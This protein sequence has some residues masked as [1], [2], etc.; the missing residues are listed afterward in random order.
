MNLVEFLQN[1]VIKGWKFWNEGEGLYYDAPSEQS[2]S[3]VLA[4]LKQHKAEILQLL[5]ERP[6]IFNVYPLSYGQRALW[7]LWQLAPE[8]HA[9]NVSFA[10]RICS[11]VDMTAMSMALAALMERHP[12]LRTTYPKLGSEPIQ[13]VHQNQELDWLQIDASSWSEEQ[14]KAKVIAAHQILFDLETGP[15][16]RVRWFSCSLVD[17]VL[18]VSI[19][20]IACDRWSLDMLIHELSKLYQAQRA[21]VE[22]S[23]PPVKHT[24]LDYVSWQRKILCGTQGEKLSNYWAHQ[25]AGDL[26]ALNLP[27]DR[28]RE[29]IQTYNGATHKFKLSSQLT[30]QLKELAQRKGVTFY[31]ILLATFK[32][33]V[34]RY[35]TQEDILVGSPTSG[36]TQP[37]FAP[38]FG[39]FVDPVVIRT[40]LANNPSFNEFLTQVRQTV[41]SALTH[42]DYPFALLVENLQPHRDASRSPIFQASFALQQLQQSQDI[43]HLLENE[44]QKDVDWGGMKLR[45]FE[46]PQLEGQFDLD[47]EMVEGSSSVFGTF[48]YNTDLFDSATIER[49]AA[50]FQN[51]CSAIVQ[52]PQLAVSE[53]PLLSEAERD[54]LLVEWNDTACEYPTDKCI[55]Q[56]FEEQVERTPFAVAVVFEEEQLTYLE[57][58]TR[59]NQ[60][61]H[62]LQSLGVKPEVLVGICVERSIEMVVGLL[63]ILKAGGAYV[64]LDPNYPQE[65]LSYMLEDSGVQVLLTQ[66]ELLS[67]LPSHTAR[68]VCLDTDWAEIEQHEEENLDAGVKSDN[69]AYVIYTS[70]STGKPKGVAIEHHSLCN[71]AQAQRNLFDVQPTSRVLQFAS[72]SFDASVSEIFMAVTTGAILILAKATSLMPGE[73]LKQILHE[74][75]VTH[76]TLPPSALSVLPTDELP[77][78]GQMIVAGEACPLEL[79]NQWSVGRRFFNAYGP[80]ESTV[81]ATIADLSNGFEKMT[82]GRPIANTQIYI[83]DKYLQPVPIGVPGELYI[84]GDGL[85]RGYLNRPQL[86]QE[87][88]IPNPFNNSKSERLYKTGDLARYR[89][90][91]NIE[92]LGRIDNQV[93]IRGFRIELSEIEA[94]LNTHPQIE[95]AV[96]IAKEDIPGNK[97]L[98]AYVV[99]SDESLTIYQIRE[100]L[101]QKLPE[102]MVP[103]AFVTLDTLKLTPNGKVDRFALPAPDGEITREHEYVP[104]RTPSEEIIAN[105]FAVVLGVQNV[106][107]HDNFFTLG[108]H[109][110]LATQ[111]ISRLRVA[112]EVEIPLRTIFESPTVTQLDQ[113]ITQLRQ[114]DRRLSLPPIEPLTHN[115]QIPLSWA[116]ERLWFLNQ[117][118]GPSSTYNMPG[119]IRVSGQLDINAFQQALSE[120][121]RRHEVLRTRFQSLNGTPIQ[122]IHPEATININLVDLQ[123]YSAGE[124]ETLLYQKAQTEAI[125]PFELEIAPLIRCSLLQLSATEYVLLVTMHHIVSDGWSIGV[126]IQELSALYPAFCA[127][128]PSPLPE[129]PIQYADFAVWQ[130]Q[131][132]SGDVLQ[133]QLNYWR[134]QLAL[135]PE[136]LQLPTDRPRPSVQTYHGRTHNRTINIDL[137]Q[138][139]QS[140]SRESGTTLFMTLLAAFSTLLYRYTGQSDILVGT[141]IANRNRTEIESL[142]GFFVNTLVLRTR[143]EEHPSFEKLL[144]QVRETTLKAYEHQDV[145]FEQVVEA[146]QPQRSLS[147]SPLFQ[148]MFVLQNAPMG[149]LELPGVTLSKLDQESTIAQFDLT[150]SFT[151]TSEGL[152][153]SWEYNTD[154]FDSATVERMAAHYQNLC[155]AIVE[156]PHIC[157][158]E[159]PLLSEAE[160]D[161]LL[162]EWNDTACE[163]PTD[164]CIHQLFE[165]QVERTPFAVAVV[166]EE[167]QLTYQEL[168]TR[169]NQLAHH[170]QSLGVNAEVLVG[171]CTERSIEMVV[172]LLAILKAGGAY[173]PLDPNYP[174]ERFSYMLENSGV[175]V[176]L[177]HSKL[178]SSL[179]SHTAQVVC[180][181]TDWGAIEQQSQD[182]L[183]VGVSSDNLAYVIYTSGSTGQPKGVLVTHQ[184]L[185]NH[186]SAIASEYNL[187]SWDRVLQFAALSFDVAI[188]E[189]FPSWLSGATVVL[190][191]QEMF[192]SFADLVEFI[193]AERL[194]VLNLPAAFWHEWVLD[195]SQSSNASRCLRLVVVGSEQV[196]WSRVAIWQKYF[197]SHIKLYNAYG[198]TEATITAT[199][200]QPDLRHQEEKTGGVPIGRPIANTQVYILD[201]NLQ[202]VPI[203]VPGELYI[204]GDGLAR[205]Y[206]NRPELTQETFIQNPFCD[207]KSQ[208]LYKT[209]DLARYRC[210]GNIEF[211]GRIDHQVKIR[212]FRIELREIEAVLNAHPQ[213]QQAVVIATEDI[214]GHKRLVAYVVPSNESFTT[215]QLREFLKHKLPEY[216]VPSAFVTLDTLK[217]TPNGKVDRKALPAPDGE[218]T[219]EHGYVAPRTV[220]EQTLTNIWQQL[221]LKEKV[222]IH[223]NFFEIG[224]DSIV[225]IQ[226]VSRAKNSGIQITPKQIFQNQTIAE[227]ARVANT[228]VSVE[229]KQGLVT[230]V[231][232]LTPIQHGFFAQNLQEAHHYNQSV[233]LQIPNDIKPE[234]IEKAV[235]KLLEHHD[236]LRLRFTSVNS[237]HKQINH[238]LDDSVPFTI[239]DLSSTPR[240]EQPQALEKIATEYQ[241]SLNLSTGPI[242]QV[243]MFNL[244]SE[245][246]A[247]LL[248]IIHHL[249][250]DGVSWRILLSDLKTVYQQLIA[251]QPLDLGAKTTAFIDWAEKLKNYAQSEIIKQ[252][253]DYW[254]NQ[255]WSKTTPLPLDYDRIKPENTVGSAAQ[256]SV[257]LNVEE[258]RA[259]LLSVNEA[260]NTQ[261]NDI[262]LSALVV[263]LAQWTGNPT[264]VIDLEGHGREEIFSDVDLSRTVGWF[265]S[266]FPVLLQLP[267]LNQ[268]ASVIKSIKEQLRAIPNRGIGY[269]ILH[270]LCEDSSVNQQLQTIPTPEIS[271]NYLGQFDS[272]QSQTG[273]K[274]APESTGANHSSK[275]LRDHLLDINALVV[276]GELKIDWTYSSHVHAHGTVENVAQSYIQAIRS[277]IEHCQSEEAKG[278]TPSDFPLAQLNQLEL[279]ELLA[280]FRNQ[281]IESIYA[282]SPMQQGMLFHSLYA[283][284]S[285]VY[286]EEM[287]LSLKGNVNV[288]AFEQAWQKIVDRY[289]ILR[290][291]FVWENRPTPLQVVLKQVNLPWNNL[292]WRELSTTEQQQQL[293]ELLSTERKQGFQF[294]QA[295]LMRCTLIQLTDDSYKFIWSHHHILMDGWCLPIIFKDVLSFYEAEVKGETCHL[296]T[297]RPYHDYIAWLNSQDKEAAAEFWRQTL[298]GFSAPTPL[299]VDKTQYQNHQQDSNYFELELRLSAE[300]SRGLQSVAQQYHLTLSTIVQAAW[301]LLLSR[302]SGEKDI[303]FG[304]TVSGR[305]GSLSEVEN[306]VG[307][308]I[309]TLPLRLIISSQEQLIPWLQQ[310]QQFML[311]LQHHS[312]TPLVDI[313]ALSELKGGTPLFESIVVFENYPV[314][315]SLLNE[316][317]SLQLSEIEGFEQT[318]YPLT[319]VAVPGDELLVKISYDTVRFEEDTIRRMLGHLQT[320]FSAIVENPQLAVSELPL[321]SEAERDQLLVEWND[322]ACEYPTD[323]CIHQLFEEQ[324]ERTPFAVAVVFEEEQLTYLELNTRANQLAHYL[325]SLGVKP[326]VLVGICVER[327][328]EMVVGLLGILKAGG[329][330]VPLDPNYPQERL[331]Y[332]LEDSG[333]QVLLTQQELL[334]SLPSHTAR[335][336]CLDT[337]WAEIEQHEE[338][339]LDAG[340]KSDNLAYV[341]YTSG[342]TGKPKGVAIEHHS[343]CNL[344]QAQRN[345]FDVQ[346]TSRVLQFA[347]ISFDA[348]VSEIF[349][350]V[351]T[352]AILILAK[353]TS[354]MPGE[355]LKQILHESCVTHVTLPPSA[356]SVLPTDELPALGQMIVAG[357]ACP[358]EL[359]N[360]WS[361]GRRFFNAYGPTESTVCAT[362]ADLSNGFEKMTI[363]RPIANTQIYILDKYLQPVPIGVPGE[364]YIGGDGLARGYLNRPQ[365]TQEKFIPN[366]FNNSKSERLYKTG[367]LARYRS[368]G[369]IEFLGRIDN[370]V[371]I[372]GF[373][374]E[375]SE[376]EAV[377]N[378]HPQI[379]Q[380]VVIA[381]EDI[382]GNKRLVAYVVSSDESLTIYQI[383][384]FLKQKLPEYMVPSTF[385]FLD[386]FP[387]TPNGKIDR[388]ALPTPDEELTRE[389]EFVPPR[390]NMEI[391]VAQIWSKV[392]NIAP[393]GIRDNF[394]EIGGN[395]L[396]AVRLM[397]LIQ[398]QFETNLPLATL[399]QSPTIE[400]IADIL[401]Q[402]TGSLSW[403]PLVPIRETG[404]KKPFFCVPGGGGNVIYF[405]NLA[406]HLGSDQPF[407]GLQ[408]RGLDGQS[409]PYTRVE[410]MA[411][412][413]IEAIQKVQP[414]GPYFL[415]GHSFGSQVAFEMGQQLQRQGHEVALVAILDLAAPVA[416]QIPKF[417][418][419]WV[420]RLMSIIAIIE[421]WLETSLEISSEILQTLSEEEQFDYLKERLVIANVLAPETG[422][423]QVR[424]LV[425]IFDANNEA[426]RH[427]LPLPH[428]IHSSPIVLFRAMELSK[429]DESNAEIQTEIESEPTM[430]WSDF[431][432]QPV[433]IQW[434]PGNHLTMMNLPHVQVLAQRLKTCIEKAQNE[435]NYWDLNKKEEKNRV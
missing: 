15:I 9:Y 169:A 86:T 16:M 412:F 256:V 274:F 397:A 171:I 391:Q 44:T 66:Q 299:V 23:L 407:Y 35:T 68:V 213:I 306:M 56:L 308:F 89:S 229:C 327:S 193:N 99:S 57:L 344:A 365:L 374:I 166:F 241:A 105:I 67:S 141:P 385:V 428:E 42:Q 212:G 382:P 341:I 400:Q 83:L 325:Q 265:T 197:D 387:L 201:S 119:A 238:G 222:S 152:V 273:W 386:T 45:P 345:L 70:G 242:M 55:H 287:T 129:L 75:C 181:D 148:V 108:G 209:G 109:S 282:L 360:Q 102:Y 195:L 96:V 262:L 258:T 98:V 354:L 272:V 373:R 403:S 318:N 417:D 154:L 32:V 285:G 178:L 202:P 163:Y 268:P 134:D 93:K 38:I 378:T 142:I 85:A 8:S 208:R 153:G 323:K 61:A 104:P 313:Q 53:L 264:V 326:E 434:V 283:P 226:V 39:Y 314:D 383:R 217:L 260:Y 176:L 214:P 293:S 277:I 396:L 13:Q 215:N 69:L 65:R 404:S 424:A 4:Q 186:S 275:L 123:Q 12:I 159:L 194:T 236:A 394:F 187:S 237:E 14:L 384:E 218:I 60:L 64:P 231:A 179:P 276:E 423:N 328:I 77:A 408:A 132:L 189:I 130:R 330:Y 111:L 267:P 317:G 115:S 151:E 113:T 137:T 18:L 34:Y 30:E 51:L 393:V 232:P 40:N 138:K 72:I 90:D 133:N 433:D 381:K 76:V 379:E 228:T 364:L 167:E 253:L 126:F 284:S 413:Y 352:G 196:Q 409:K 216:M 430:G 116:Q 415:G 54:Q 301:A 150:V 421:G 41:L 416:S 204:G 95:Q 252:E 342:S 177:T 219:R 340:V 22:I 27:T 180:L 351:T 97:R 230:G 257:K 291:F 429:F 350:A 145:P 87:K 311:E 147:H 168:N 3:S 329:A 88:F 335:V 59:A 303:V 227:L 422:T 418:P 37:E 10:V 358:L 240:V 280:P 255:P 173:V 200:Y 320:I 399:F 254:R 21:G 367:D 249:A 349:M 139:L 175:Q 357:E 71:L 390:N 211:L 281:N 389:F 380:A 332:M 48:K 158:G 199:V 43:L 120:I 419:D 47:L 270:Y 149:E 361:V 94:V 401:S 101:K 246:D 300:V 144:K 259:L 224:G 143:F 182:N 302:Y 185:V 432:T 261:I 73:D 376:I 205:G 296:P 156:N 321:L 315:S 370:Q 221:F 26:P 117:L 198:P 435:V 25:L 82:I 78:L 372:R 414:N 2:T 355:D 192:A 316:G 172:G 347:S 80:T 310:I 278:Y 62:Y 33:L 106:G 369:N 122:V 7:F 405:Y 388:N 52:N 251:E 127:G 402:Q 294:N 207:S 307:L 289:S 348:S 334:S 305:S 46:I 398:Q 368:D 245:S 322:T 146:L 271:F 292:D 343:L 155:S 304:V 206:L 324:V 420:S 164:K 346:P 250:V 170:L 107:I 269:G 331:S 19:H 431:T 295:P 128:V 118:E 243:V 124:R 29:P 371:K 359:V 203:G 17:H 263:S 125:T 225:S 427:Y 290:T 110:L 244:G 353:A 49:M 395:S 157:V 248:I 210:D 235:E 309:N 339:N 266:L 233:F 5:Q 247:R 63:G 375:L 161:Q 333:V 363:G 220:I 392:L 410:D 1:L 188:E 174:K 160:R 28:Q 58:N 319:V 286:F 50:H 103:S 337:D 336:V 11:V 165:E 92:F 84:G 74:S 366:P 356:L 121:V 183:D 234:L 112:L 81:C 140:L 91:G 362:I 411:S 297:P 79:V 338:E 312:Y 377:L 223:D 279:D 6:D 135:A 426:A 24:Y 136:L 114:N 239:V 298:Q 100:F 191:P 131:W 31:M 20:H 190:R 425:Q 288:A 184:N 406:R 162:V 36:R